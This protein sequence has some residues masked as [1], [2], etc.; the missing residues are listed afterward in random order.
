VCEQTSFF[1][2]LQGQE[3]IERME[4]DGRISENLFFV[5]KIVQPVGGINAKDAHSFVVPQINLK[6]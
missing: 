5:I 1:S 6:V 3:L 2:E 4:S